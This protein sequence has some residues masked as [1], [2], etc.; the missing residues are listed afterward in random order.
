[1]ADLRRRQRHNPIE[2]QVLTGAVADV[3]NPNRL[4]LLIDFMEDSINT[5][6]PAEQEAARATL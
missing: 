5:V 1:V 6:T 3:K 4:P 2:F